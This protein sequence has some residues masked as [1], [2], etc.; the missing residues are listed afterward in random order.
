MN[1]RPDSRMILLTHGT[2]SGIDWCVC[3]APMPGANGYVRIPEGHPWAGL[4]YDYIPATAPGG[5]TFDR[6]G[7][8][9][10]DTMHLG[11]VWDEEAIEEL[12]SLGATWADSYRVPERLRRLDRDVFWTLHGVVEYAKDLACQVAD[13]AA[14]K[15]VEQ[16]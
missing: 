13:A 10:F 14:I 6:N 12:E 1:D 5:L 9:G 15:S 4:D 7:W 11:D 3:A 16:S 8:I 2:E